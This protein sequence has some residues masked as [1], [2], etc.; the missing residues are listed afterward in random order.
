MEGDPKNILERAMKGPFDVET[1]LAAINALKMHA[2]QIDIDPEFVAKPWPQTG[3]KPWPQRRLL[4]YLR[5]NLC[6]EF[7]STVDTFRPAAGP[8]V[9]AALEKYGFKPSLP[10]Y[11]EPLEP[12]PLLNGFFFDDR[13]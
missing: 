2:A 7:N 8:M 11:I 13:K 5:K 1:H 10:L 3:D 9:R 12:L 4:D 6:G